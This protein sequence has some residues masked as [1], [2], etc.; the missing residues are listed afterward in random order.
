MASSGRPLAPPASREASRR[1]TSTAAAAGRRAAQAATQARYEA[2]VEQSHD[3]VMIVDGEQVLR[4]G[5][6]AV[7]RALGY[8]VEALVGTRIPELIHP[9]DLPGVFDVIARL[10]PEPGAM[11]TVDFRMLAADGSWHF[12]ETSATNL[13]HEP[14]IEGFVISLKDVT[15]RVLTEGALKTSE[16]R[17]QD[18]VERSHELI[19]SAST[20]GRFR[21]VNLA[22]ELLTGYSVD[23]LLTMSVFD[24]VVP[25]ERQRAAEAL[26]RVVQGDEAQGIEIELQAKDGRRVFVEVRT[27]LVA[28]DGEPPH[29]EGLARDVTQRHLLEERLRYEGIHDALTGLPNRTLLLDRL[30]RA[31]E[32]RGTGHAAVAVMLLDINEFKLVNDDLGHAAGDEV[33]VELANRFRKL[34]RKS[35]TLARFGGDEFALVAEGVGAKPGLVT[36]AERMLSAFAQPFIAAGVPRKLTGSL[37][38]AVATDDATPA[39]LLR[40]ADTAMYRVKATRGGSFAFFDTAMR[41][42]LVQQNALKEALAG[43]LRDDVLEVHYQPIVSLADGTVLAVEA[44]VRWHHPEWGWVL[45]DDFIPLAEQSGLIVALGRHVLNE[46]ARQIAMWRAADPEALPLGVF[47][48]LSPR[49]LAEPG[50][51]SYVAETLAKH[52]VKQD[53]L[54]FELTERVFIDTDDETVMGNLDSIAGNGIRLILDDFGT[55]YSA[56][57]SLKRLPF[58]ALKIDRS[59]IHAI[60]TPDADA[61]ITR[62]IVGLGKSLGLAVIAEGIETET[63]L[64]YLRNLECTAAQGFKLGRPQTAADISALITHRQGTPVAAEPCVAA[65]A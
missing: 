18:L 28:D 65:S 14:A 24:L 40:D 23:E 17:Y 27:H 58:S 63:Q 16:R 39:Q 1:S 21:S 42:Q 54:A 19:Y 10:S 62:A 8:P 12:M 31:L 30:A 11:G 15:A 48:N 13:L 35:E 36:L 33:L 32:Q 50:F 29:I 60:E 38:I 61:P 34:L 57:S 5:N 51:L 46:A 55:G 3:L 7:Q 22:T 2:I 64:D 20:D 45:P 9:E 4:W 37:G 52:H 25:E 47:V 49:E 43:A 26:S 53:D 56:L 41:D 44:L 6:A 59:F